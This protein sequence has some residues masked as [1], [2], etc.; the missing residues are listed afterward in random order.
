MADFVEVI[1]AVDAI[2]G[3]DAA[4]AYRDAQDSINT[5]V[6]ESDPVAE[7]LVSW[8]RRRPEK[9]WRGAAEELLRELPRPDYVPRTWPVTGQ[10]LS[11]RLRRA[12]P[13]LREMGIGVEFGKSNRRRWISLRVV[14]Q[15]QD[16]QQ[17]ELWRQ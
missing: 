3:T 8:L 14:E 5:Q 15:P 17:T 13:A 9:T 7:A 2:R 6:V 10:S 11:G 12:A 16:G 4:T 1:A